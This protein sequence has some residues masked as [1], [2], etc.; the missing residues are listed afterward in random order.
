[1]KGAMLLNGW[2]I[3]DYLS[4]ASWLV[5]LVLAAALLVGVRSLIV[6]VINLLKENP[7]STDF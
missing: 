3:S 5:L 1:M 6:F 7:T 4:I 2:L